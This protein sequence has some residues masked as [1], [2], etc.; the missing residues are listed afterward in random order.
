MYG[1]AATSMWL[2]CVGAALQLI[3]LSWDAVVHWLDP[4]LTERE[5]V[6]TLINPGH[7]LTFGGLGLTVAGLVW[8]LVLA[9]S[10]RNGRARRVRRLLAAAM[11]VSL[12]AGLSGL[13]LVAGDSPQAEHSHPAGTSGEIGMAVAAG[14]TNILASPTYTAL[15]QVLRERGTAA[16]LDGLEAAAARDQG[17]LAVAHDYVHALGKFSFA[18]YGSAPEAFGRCRETFQSG[19]YHGVL[20]AYLESNPNLGSTELRDLCDVSIAPDAAN[21]VR[22]QCLHGLGHGLT[23]ISQHDIFKALRQCDVLKDEWDRSSCYGGVFMENVIFATRQEADA[24]SGGQH[25][26]SGGHQAALDPQDPLY[27]CNVVDDRYKRECF[28]MQTSAILM[29]NGRDFAQAF[30][31]CDRAPGD[32]VLLCYQ[33]MGRDISS[34]TYRDPAE[35]LQMCLQ[36]QPAYVGHCLVGAGKNMIDVT[37]QIDQALQLCGSAASDY[38]A[39]CYAAIG[40]QVGNLQPDPDAQARECRRSEQEYILACARGAGLEE[41]A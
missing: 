41:P 29:F 36:G 34:E 28:V 1:R 27:P 14:G 20:E 2:A 32:F 31:E 4:T 16:A 19:C 11:L 17:I 6:F 30:E 24:G 8:L 12:L 21:A 13:G 40:E 23:G 7:L 26:H 22:F 38:K 3:G 35:S 9:G 10:R 5:S 25:D 39:L 37:W 15:E 33:S 18:F